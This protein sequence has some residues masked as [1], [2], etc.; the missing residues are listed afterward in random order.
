MK[1]LSLVALLALIA[2]FLANEAAAQRWT[3]PPRGSAER[4]ALLDALRPMAEEIFGSPVEF[5]VDT[6]RVSGDVAFVSVDAQRPGGGRIDVRRTPG[7]AQGYFMEDAYHIGGQA[8]M[9][10]QGGRWQVADYA[11]GATD[12]WWISRENC[13]AFR[14]VI[15]DHCGRG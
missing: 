9:R 4:R 6:M 10:R 5:M 13:A 12:V 8:L 7:W 1:Q 2:A 14:A 3:E 15:A 11:F